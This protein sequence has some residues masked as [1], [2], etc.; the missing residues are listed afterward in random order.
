[1]R[2]QFLNSILN[3][4]FPPHPD[5]AKAHEVSRAQLLDLMQ[6][7]T[8]VGKTTFTCL[9]YHDAR[10]QAVIRANKFYGSIHA[11]TILGAVLEEAL[12]IFFEENALTLQW[13]H[14][15]ITPLPAAPKRKRERGYN[16]V[17]HI[18][19]ALPPDVLA[20]CS[21]RPD[22]LKRDNRESQSWLTRRERKEN[23]KNSFYVPNP[24]ARSGEL[25]GASVL[26]ID[27]VIESG[28]TM[29]DAMRALKAAGV[30]HVAGIAL[31]Q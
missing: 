21:Y 27:D 10:V 8:A 23:I 12:F 1:M 15:I 30:R 7:R 28:A 5:V 16:Q 29:K 4:I 13:N 20:E 6:Y 2:K 14:P 22:I 3:L 24:I 31:A 11:S 18:M 19:Q 26:L 17:V 9:P 25:T